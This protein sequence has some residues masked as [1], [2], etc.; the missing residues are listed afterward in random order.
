MEGL[1]PLRG[2]ELSISMSLDAMI[3]IAIR[4]RLDD[5]GLG[6][7]GGSCDLGR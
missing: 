6:T 2:G 7:H 1:E 3:G 4:I 5:V